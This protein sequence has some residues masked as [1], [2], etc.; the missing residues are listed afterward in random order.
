MNKLN[1]TSQEWK[2]F[3]QETL[4]SLLITGFVQT[5]QHYQITGTND[6]EIFLGHTHM[7][8]LV[9]C[10]LTSNNEGL[11]NW[12]Q[13]I[14]LITLQA[15]LLENS[16]IKNRNISFINLT[17]FYIIPIKTILKNYMTIKHRSQQL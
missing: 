4:P 12:K 5:N 10:D 1:S 6:R 3:K 15:I 13:I 16:N 11:I 7:T 9:C 17:Q 2:L 8:N 14:N